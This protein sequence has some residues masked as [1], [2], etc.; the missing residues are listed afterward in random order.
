MLK[1][2]MILVVCFL[3]NIATPLNSFTQERRIDQREVARLLNFARN[4]GP[5][6]VK[7][8]VM[9][10]LK[11][12][13]TKR[14]SYVKSL[15]KTLNKTK[16][17]EPLKG[18]KV[19]GQ[20]AK[21]WAL[22]S[23]RKGV[24]GHGNIKKRLFYLISKKGAMAENCTYGNYTALDAVMS[25]LIDEGISSLGHR[26]NILNPIYQKV[27]IAYAKHTRYGIVLVMNFSVR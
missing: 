4:D 19:L 18:D 15:I 17:V 26:K 11:E 23:G 13:G 21:E 6:F 25:L 22:E 8:V 2:W 1:N 24:K 20:K 27:G 7:E 16:G 14:T 5:K 3:F 10:Y 12:N 9:P